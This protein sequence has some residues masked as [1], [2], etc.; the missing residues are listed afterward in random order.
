MKLIAQANRA[1]QQH[2]YAQAMHDYVQ[3][4]LDR[5]ELK[6]SLKINIY[7]AQRKYHKSREARKK[8]GVAVCGWALSNN[9]AGRVYTL[10][11][12]YEQFA[13]VSIIG[14]IFPNYGREIWQPIRHSKRFSI[15][16]FTVENEVNFL[17]QAIQFVAKYPYDIVHLSKPRIS[18]IIIGLLYKWLWNA[19][20]IMDI[21]DEELAFVNATSPLL[22]D[23]YLK[24]YKC[25][26]NWEQL[27]GEVWTRLAVGLAKEFDGITVANPALQQR[28][29][30]EV[31]RHARDENKFQPSVG[32]RQRSRKTYGIPNNVTVILFCGTPRKH[33]GLIDIAQAVS[34]LSNPNIWF[35]IVGDFDQDDLPLKQQLLAV[36]NVHYHF[37]ATQPFEQLHKVVAIA[38]ISLFP[39]DKSSLAA[40]FQTPAKLS[41]VLAMGIIVMATETPATKDLLQA[42]N[43]FILNGELEKWV[44]ALRKITQET[45]EAK[46]E[47]QIQARKTF[48]QAL[49][50]KANQQNLQIYTQNLHKRLFT[51]KLKKFIDLDPI[52]YE[53][54][55]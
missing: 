28:Y 29:G 33:K 23:D 47:R 39:Q 48:L 41:D 53:L 4:L 26:P 15:H 51:K 35:V 8:D 52:L 36:P 49:S 24:E 14:T 44:Y 6:K 45:A 20:I 32:L 38:D 55:H 40:Q 12:L 18:N 16:Y 43:S 10:A 13:D 37:I 54:V 3:A 42:S 31:I 27:D 1:L 5:P 17:N 34:V 22:L 2:Q 46:K 21:D 50:L 25:L 7:Q 19:K 9:A 11:C 30:G